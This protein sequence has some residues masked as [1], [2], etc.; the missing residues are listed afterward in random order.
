MAF[1]AFMPVLAT[2]VLAAQAA[3]GTASGPQVIV[4][5]RELVPQ[6]VS[7]NS[8]GGLVREIRDPHSGDRWLLSRDL[9][10]PEGPGRL[11]LVQHGA[12]RIRA[13][14]SGVAPAAG[15]DAGSPSLPLP[16]IHAGDRLIVEEHSDVVEARLEAVAL[17]AAVTGS[18]LN[19]RLSIG[20]RVV[21]AVA[22]GPGRAVFARME[23][24]P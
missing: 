5:S 16:V 2:P 20:G 8:P 24:L 9:K 22:L 21:R 14:G 13:T 12:N 6:S 23:A 18:L 1:L 11:V 17:D 19:V 15:D 4:S 10:H 7:A 3:G